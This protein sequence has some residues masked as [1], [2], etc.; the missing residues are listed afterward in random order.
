M[1]E[2]RAPRT[3]FLNEAHE[4]ARGE[5]KGGGGVPKYASINWQA[6]GERIA[7]SLRA[8]RTAVRQSPDPVRETRFFLLSKAEAKI[9]KFSTDKRKSKDGRVVEEIHPAGKHA[10]I[11]QRLGLDLLGVTDR[12]EALVHAEADR[13]DRLLATADALGSAGPREQAR[14]ALLSDFQPAPPETRADPEWISS[15]PLKTTVEAIVE[16]QP[17]LLRTEV[18]AV[19]KALRDSIAG[20]GRQAVLAAGRDFSGR[21]WFRMRLLRQTVDAFARQF[22]SIQ[23]IHPPL[24][25]PLAAVSTKAPAVAGGVAVPPITDAN[26]PAVAIVD[27]GIPQQH[28]VLA[29]YRRGQFLHAEAGQPGTDDHASRVASRIVFGD[30]DASSAGYV[31]PPGRCQFLDVVV[32]S[33]P[34]SIGKIP[35]IDLDNKAIQDVIG[36]VTRNYPDVRVFDFSFGSHQPLSRLTAVQRREELIGV[37]DLDNFIFANDVLVVVAAGNSPRGAVPNQQ[38]PG[39][40]DDPDWGLGAWACG[41][42]TLVI[43]SYVGQPHSDGLAGHTGWP[44]PFTRIGPGL[45][46]APVPSFSASGGDSTRNY[47]YQS[48]LGVWTCGRTGLWEDAVGTSFAAPI[49]AR[50]AAILLQQLQRHCAPGIPCFAATA[51]AFLRLVA[52]RSGDQPF[53]PRV[54]K[55]ADLT[56]GHGLPTAQRLARPRASSAVLV[57]QGTL[58]DPASIARV[59]VPVPPAWVAAAQ[60]PSLRVVCAWNTPVSAAAPDVWASRKVVMHLKPTLGAEAIRGKGKS[61][62]SYPITDRVWR[63]DRDEEGEPRATP[64]S[65]EWVVELFYEDV[66]PYPATLQISPQQQVSLVM[67]LFDDSSTPISPQEELQKLPIAET[68]IRLAGVAREV[69]VPVK[70]RV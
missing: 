28:P 50:E 44:S 62:R 64:P 4:H 49:V 41:F 11:F 47:G 25:S 5:K 8:A 60:H 58:E 68:M 43:G 53:P 24:R 30:V 23:S 10:G 55:L 2:T 32:P 54:R 9:E 67:E 21:S 37:Q 29:R 12:G 51:R 33:F 15:I 38:Y 16:I 22:Q 19:A 3:F 1:A 34:G 69:Q 59:R 13:L 7:K 14:W 66:G 61:H 42:N 46:E 18:E 40:V 70:I 48:P 27:A 57:W 52:R 26:L 20:D 45:A 6:K 17:L 39:H 56:L 35:T 65:D 31:P 63:L 36:D